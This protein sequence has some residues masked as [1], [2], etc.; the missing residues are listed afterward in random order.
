MESTLVG[1][2]PWP[3][4]LIHGYLY[5]TGKHGSPENLPNCP[6]KALLIPLIPTT[7]IGTKPERPMRKHV[8]MWVVIRQRLNNMNMRRQTT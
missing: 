7:A 3:V 8:H 6:E 5:A 1:R 2:M 4:Q